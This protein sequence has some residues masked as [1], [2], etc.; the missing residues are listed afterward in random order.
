MNIALR[1]ALVALLTFTAG[2]LLR[3]GMA[4]G[5]RPARLAM[6]LGAGFAIGVAAHAIHGIPGLAGT[7]PWWH[8]PVSAFEAGNAIVFWLFTRALFDDAFRLRGWHPACWAALAALSVWTCLVLVPGNQAQLARVTGA[9]LTTAGVAFAALAAAQ[10]LAGWRGDLVEDRRR[11]RL[12][13]LGVGAGYSLFNL[14]LRLAYP[15]ADGRPGLPDAA[16]T[17]DVAVLMTL[18]VLVLARVLRSDRAAFVA[19]ARDASP[20]GTPPVAPT[21]S[22][23]PFTA[24]LAAAAAADRPV[25]AAALL[26][27]MDED[28]VYREEGLGI[29]ALA[30]RLGIPEYRLRR[31]INQHLGHR[32][33][34]AFLNTWRLA[35]VKAALADPAR[36]SVPIL[37]LALGAGFQAIGPFSRAFQADTGLTPSE[38]RAA[39]QPGVNSR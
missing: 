36:A 7:T 6:L 8:G 9:V 17:T 33:F 37:T 38:F 5:A 29:G 1:A 39:S 31:L 35:E 23:R 12:W 27:A 11:L 3:D 15:T 21:V 34:T 4:A 16:N 10:T 24:D 2:L 20:P 14:A 13:V 32:N 18:A 30:Q 22:S 26:R 25:L 28:R 19:A